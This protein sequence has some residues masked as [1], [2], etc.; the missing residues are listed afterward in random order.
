MAT[1]QIVIEL[2]PRNV[3]AGMAEVDGSLRR[4]AGEAREFERAAAEAMRAV[5]KSARE[6]AREQ[7]RA[8]RAA[9]KAAADSA[10]QAASAQRAAAREVDETARALIIAAE[11]RARERAEVEK[12]ATR[13][14][15]EAAKK[16]AAERD[17]AER[18]A[19]KRTA[20]YMAQVRADYKNAQAALANTYRS[21]VGPAAE[22]REKLNQIIQLER[23]GAITA[24]QRARAVAAMNRD[25]RQFNAQQQGGVRGA[26]SSALSS[27]FGAVA[28]PAAVAG[29]AIKAGQELVELGDEYTDLSNKIRQAT[30]SEAE[31][32][33][34]RDRLFKSAIA[35][36]VDVKQLTGLYAQ[37][38]I[39][40]KDL[41]T[42]QG[43]LLRVSELLA[44]ATRGVADANKQAGLQQFGQALSKGTL[45]AEELMSI[46]ENIPRVGQLLA[47]GMG[48]TVGELRKAASEGKIGTQAMLD[49]IER[50]GPAIE[51]NFGKSVATTAEAW[52]GIKNQVL[53]TVGGFAEQI[54]LGEGV[55][56]VVNELGSALRVVGGLVQMQLDTWRSIDR[57]TGGIAGKIAM[58]PGFFGQIEQLSGRI[59]SNYLF[60]ADYIR[61]QNDL[62]KKSTAEIEK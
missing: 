47:E 26:V 17:Q 1:H 61:L 59:A 5:E 21:V 32:A 60:G 46:M 36:R 51:A 37:M 42:S 44:K 23:Q 19:A 55:T 2:D 22:Y 4:S 24:Q 52:T 25:V 56:K 18:F 38:R 8:T 43:E 58:Q 40:T 12:K 28:G 15:A 33:R 6:A 20:D 29:L 50:M 3:K 31:M 48:M 9:A 14:A 10:R 39:A 53:E 54:H 41:G 7:E 30:E 13:D 35:A 27:Q 45:Q 16:A 34:V 62:L 11:R 49:A 57:A